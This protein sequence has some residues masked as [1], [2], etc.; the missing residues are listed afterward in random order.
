MKQLTYVIKILF[1]NFT[2]L[3]TFKFC[4]NSNG[5]VQVKCSINLIQF[6]FKNGCFVP[7][8]VPI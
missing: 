6:L 3:M 2:T 8:K 5:Q 4:K 1:L 7:Q